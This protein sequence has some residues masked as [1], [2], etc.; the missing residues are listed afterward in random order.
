MR[1]LFPPELYTSIDRCLAFARALP[2][3]SDAPPSEPVPVHFFWQGREFGAKPALCLKSFLATQ[4]PR[5]FRAWLWLEDPDAFAAASAH[6][7]LAPLLP[8]LTLRHYDATELAR[9][10]PFA[11]GA[12]T[13]SLAA[14]AR[15]DVA[16]LC[17]LARHGGCY[18]DLD[19]LFL[20]DLTPLLAL[21]G[22]AEFCFQWSAEPSGTNA[23]CRH[24]AGSANLAELMHR[25][26]A[27]RS[28]HPRQ[29]L[30]VEG[31]PEHLLLLPVALF[32]P[33]WL[34]RDGR[35]YSTLA[36]FGGFDDFFQKF[37]WFHRR[38]SAVSSL[39]TFFPGAFTY[40]WHGRWSAR[41]H[42]ESYAGLL[43]RD[44]GARIAARHPGLGPLP[45]LG[46]T[47]PK[48]AVSV[49]RARKL[50]LRSPL[51]EPAVR[52]RTLVVYNRRDSLGGLSKVQGL[53]AEFYSVLGALHY[54]E[55]HGAAAVRPQFDSSL[56]LYPA[57][58]PNW[59]EYFFTGPMVI[60]PARVARGE[61][62]C[63]GL[64]RYGPCCWNDNWSQI[65]FPRSSYLRPYPI[66]SAAEIREAARLTQRYVRIAPALAAQVDAL[67]RRHV[68]PGE[69]VIGLH[70]RGTD[71]VE[72]YPH[73]SPDFSGYLE[74]IARV[75]AARRPAHYK[76]FVATDQSD[77]AAAARA[78]LGDR[79]I[80]L[81]ATPRLAAA[82]PVARAL[83]THKHPGFG[84]REKGTS[85]LLDCLLLAR[86][87]YLIKNRS[88]LSDAAL[89]FNPRLPW[90]F[91]LNDG[92][93]YY[94]AS[95]D[96]TVLPCP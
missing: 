13:R 17:C 67:W 93:V 43:D 42:R 65:I 81:D 25:A 10:T 22:D 66:D 49:L 94:G 20:R 6:P 46:E 61:V 63:R 60:D 14:P 35:D 12:W 9:G 95:A 40:H 82:D 30:A 78:A 50:R 8:A 27:V 70:L 62:H 76:I 36:P 91:I 39:D 33:L 75:V 73:R 84:P 79:C 47:P 71:K 11:E 45:G 1:R 15:S 44:C 26:V 80:L 19:A 3:P 7:R 48:P 88:A 58:G 41:E 4:D 21:A 85:A 23:F 55:R 24:H 34:Q 37:G 64:H 51:P 74:H 57:R 56:Y 77:Y 31:A 54:A 5:R 92:E 29:L 59:W 87:D 18:S 32:S 86:C 53:F 52:D 72:T 69:F 96:G 28:A 38:N 83:G 16:R 90:T 89:A 2:A 68:A